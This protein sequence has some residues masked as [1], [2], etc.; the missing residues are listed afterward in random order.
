MNCYDESIMDDLGTQMSNVDRRVAQFMRVVKEQSNEYKSNHL[1][2]TFGNDFTYSNSRRW[3][4]NIDKLIKHVNARQDELKVNVFYSTPECY[5]YAINREESDLE[6][7]YDDFFPYA[8]QI[9]RFWTGYLTSRPA[10]KYNVRQTSSF[11]QSAR[12]LI[13]LGDIDEAI[14]AE[15]IGVLERAM[16]ILQHHDAISGTEKQYVA[17]DYSAKLAKGVEKTFNAVNEAVKSILTRNFNKNLAQPLIHCPLLNI[18]E[19]LPIE[20]E[21]RFNVLVYNPLPRKT[22]TWITVP[23]VGLNNEVVDVESEKGIVSD[24]APVYRDIELVSE[25]KAQAN[26]RLLFKTDLAPMGFKVFRVQKNKQLNEIGLRPVNND[27]LKSSSFSLKNEKIGLRFDPQGNLI[28]VEN[29]ESGISMAIKQA[30][31]YYVSEH[32]YSGAYVFRFC[33][34]LIIRK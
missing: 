18:T 11:L 5:Q 34:S 14:N 15:S 30:L 9:S 29:F 17:N 21:D 24:T 26:Y 3:F 10:L 27:A 33:L 12:H 28:G 1:I 22:Q 6:V 13:A 20:N 16:G 2:M 31:C 4:D 23:I 8:D 19:C 7:K 32:T 25:R